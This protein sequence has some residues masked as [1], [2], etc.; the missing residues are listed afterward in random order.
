MKK[1][2]NLSRLTAV[3]QKSPVSNGQEQLYL[4]YRE[5]SDILRDYTFL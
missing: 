3:R 1:T 5:S 4:N 2:E